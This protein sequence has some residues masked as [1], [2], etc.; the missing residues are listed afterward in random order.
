MNKEWIEYKK[1]AEERP[2][3]FKNSED[4]SI[5]FDEIL[6]KEFENISGRKIGCIYKSEYNIFLVDLVIDKSGNKFAYER[7]VPN[8][9]SGAVVAIVNYKNKFVLLNQFRHAL[10][11]NQLSFPRGFGEEGLSELEN[12]K[13]ELYEE[14]GSDIKSYKYLGNVVSD[15]GIGNNRVSIFY[16]EISEFSIKTNY[17]GINDVV[18]LD[19]NEFIDYIKDNKIDDGYTLSA[20]T[21]YKLKK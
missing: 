9:K 19:E 5:V 14:L 18:L 2:E 8:A 3:L 16:C 21:L 11:G 6:V 17:E 7:L 20:Y 12:L 1:I 10:R 13:K 15:S 4:L